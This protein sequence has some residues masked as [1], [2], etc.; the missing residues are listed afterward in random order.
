MKLQVLN[1]HVYS[2]INS[3]R[4]RVD[5]KKIQGSDFFLREE[6]QLSISRQQV[7]LLSWV[8]LLQFLHYFSRMTASLTSPSPV[9]FTNYTT[10]FVFQHRPPSSHYILLKETSKELKI[11]LSAPS[12]VSRELNYYRNQLGAPTPPT[13][14]QGRTKYN[15]KLLMVEL[16]LDLRKFNETHWFFYRVWCRRS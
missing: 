8:W 9:Q 4:E 6:G 3:K 2:N 1:P 15:T 10:V 5:L 14:Q 16:C 12:K 11:R 13:R 7:A